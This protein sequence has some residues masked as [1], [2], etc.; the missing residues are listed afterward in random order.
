MER[1]WCTC[2]Y[3]KDAMELWLLDLATGKSQQLTE[4]RRGECGAA[5]VAGR[6]TDRFC[7]DVVQ[8]AISYFS[9]RTCDDGK[10]ENVVRLTGETKSHFAALLLQRVRYGDQSGLDAGWRRDSVRFES[11]AHSR[12]RADFGG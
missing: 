2:S 6:K 11:R 1:A 9:R 3:Q 7:F 8:Q 5:M 12:D 10:L 4:R